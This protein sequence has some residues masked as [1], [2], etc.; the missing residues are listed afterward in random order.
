VPASD[1]GGVAEPACLLIG[2][3][4][5]NTPTSMVA[6]HVRGQHL[7]NQGM[8]WGARRPKIRTEISISASSSAGTESLKSTSNSVVGPPDNHVPLIQAIRNR[9]VPGDR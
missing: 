7:D 6:K 5:P 2:L 4:P 8:F 3:S 9:F 1:Y